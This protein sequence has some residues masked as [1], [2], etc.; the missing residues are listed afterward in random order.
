MSD[1]NWTNRERVFHEKVFDTL[2]R[3]MSR[4]SKKDSVSPNENTG[5]MNMFSGRKVKWNHFGK[6]YALRFSDYE[7]EYADLY[8]ALMKKVHEVRPDFEG[9]VAYIDQFGRQAIVTNDKDV[10]AA[11]HQSKGKLKLHTTLR[12]G[13][14][15]SAADIAGRPA[16]SQSVPPERSYHSYPPNSRSPSSMDSAPA[17][18]RHR[19]MS[20]PPSHT[21]QPQREI[22][23]TTYSHA[24]SFSGY[25]NGYPYKA[26]YPYS[27]SILYGMPP[28]NGMLLRFL[29]N[30]FPFGHHHRTFVGPN[31]YHHFGGWGG[32]RYYSSG[33]GPVW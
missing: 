29:A 7:M 4:A 6:K 28:H 32:G 17:T 26:G 24:G 31:K 20:P 15:L 23:K 1:V 18:Y 33:F 2:S 10:R 11:I 9:D 19:T 14:V 5:T 12:E 30:P 21:P 25:G 13:A 3:P 22:I 8:D 27:Q 16:R